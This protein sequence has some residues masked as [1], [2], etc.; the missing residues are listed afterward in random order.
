[1]KT[2]GLVAVNKENRF[3]MALEPLEMFNKVKNTNVNRISKTYL[4]IHGF[5][6]TVIYAVGSRI[7]T[8]F[9]SI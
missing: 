4:K 7:T 8:N 2:Y 5:L 1:M 6:K 3:K 9:I